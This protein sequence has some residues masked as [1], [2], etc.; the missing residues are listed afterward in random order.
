VARHGER[1]RSRKRESLEREKKESLSS[2]S[3]PNSRALCAK[4]GAFTTRNTV[5][6]T[7]LYSLA[8][9]VLSVSGVEGCEIDDLE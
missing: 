8:G 4:I 7:T 3:L 5:G 9:Y 6:A 1:K 2:F